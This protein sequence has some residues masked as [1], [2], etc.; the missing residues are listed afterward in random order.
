[1]TALE[2]RSKHSASK[3]IGACAVV[4]VLAVPASVVAGRQPPPARPEAA[5]EVQE[6][7]I[8]EL[9]AALTSGAVTSRTLVLAYLARIRAYDLQGP[10]LNAMISMAPR[11]LE[12][13]DASGLSAGRE[14][15]CTGFRSS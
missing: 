9:Q 14:G 6:K 15:P 4:A 10:K 7:T 3:W 5:F 12:T 8:E 2:G 13:A 11:I 1:M